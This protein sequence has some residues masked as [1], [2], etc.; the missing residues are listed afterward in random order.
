MRNLK[1]VSIFLIIFLVSTIAFAQSSEGGYDYSSSDIY[2]QPDFYA[3]SDPTQWDL[4]KVDWNK[5]D[6]TNGRVYWNADIFSRSEPYQQNGFYQNLPDNEYN[7]L[8]YNQVDYDNINLNHDKIDSGKYVTDMGCSNCEMLRFSG[9]SVKYS[10][11]GVTHSNGDPVSI[12]GTYPSGTKFYL[13]EEGIEIRLPEETTEINI[14]TGDAV[15]I[16]TSIL[17][18]E[19][20]TGGSTVSSPQK[21]EMQYK[22]NTVEGK[23]SFKDGQ[24]YV[25]EGDTAVV[26]HIEI[27][28]AESKAEVNVYFDGERH[29]GAAISMNL[30]KR[31]M[32]FGKGV[33]SSNYGLSFQP[34]NVFLDTEEGDHLTMKPGFDS[35]MTIQHRGDDLI[36]LVSVKEGKRGIDL[37]LTNGK[38]RYLVDEGPKFKYQGLHIL[39]EE[40]GSVPFTMLLQDEAGNNIFGMEKEKEKIIFD[41]AQN[42]IIIPE[43]L[44]PEEFECKDCIVDFG[45]SRALYDFSSAKILKNGNIQKITADNAAALYRVS[46]ML[47]K[48]PPVVRDSILE[49]ELVPQ[50]QVGAACGLSGRSIGGCA[51]PNT[52]RIILGEQ[53]PLYILYHE[54][55]HTL[56]YYIEQKDELEAGRDL[57]AYELE[58][59][60]KYDV[61]DVR[62]QYESR[63]ILK[64]EEGNVIRDSKGFGSWTKCKGVDMDCF[65]SLVSSSEKKITI[66]DQDTRKW[67]ELKVLSNQKK[68]NQFSKEWQ[69]IAGE[70]YGE[71]LEVNLEGGGLPVEWADGT[72]GPKN[73]CTRAYGCNNYHEDVATFVEHVAEGDHNFYKPLITPGN[74]QYD[75]RYRKKLDLLYKSGFI[76][77]EDYH[78][79]IGE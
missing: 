78:K 79:I 26:N 60:R 62:F 3:N 24:A 77:T 1:L 20:Q 50:D 65:S 21:R 74:E 35:E 22:G 30:E 40:Q 25:K 17:V 12:P 29:E 53:T 15:T 7:K 70:V 34:G 61:E 4:N 52:R 49:L 67:V 68:E 19:D 18:I 9:A 8:D 72:Y 5:V 46:K 16:D 59:K 76:T 37:F 54:A 58:L 56:T 51:N 2:Q 28:N 10:K 55:G 11:E 45:K 36:P 73:G 27:Y 38:Q 41:N 6:W 71:G 69:D 13:K 63:K 32:Y 47:D 43:N 44:L 48:I 14:P 42:H 31:R 39:N 23:L 66:N 57:K 75:P 33:T 64:D